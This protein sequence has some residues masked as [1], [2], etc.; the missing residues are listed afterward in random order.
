MRVCT[1]L[2]FVTTATFTAALPAGSPGPA[3]KPASTAHTG[4]H[5]YLKVKDPKP[6]DKR[7]GE[8]LSMSSKVEKRRAG[9][10]ARKGEKS[11]IEKDILN[12]RRKAYASHYTPSNLAKLQPEI[13]EVTGKM[14]DVRRLFT[15][16]ALIYFLTRTYPRSCTTCPPTRL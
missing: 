2:A 3:N 8:R 12:D 4:S 7:Y 10:R 6:G 1:L 11:K 13:T 16:C 15:R 5:N 9:E 14:V